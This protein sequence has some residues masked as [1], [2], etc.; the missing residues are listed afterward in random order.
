MEPDFWHGKWQRDETAFHE[1]KPNER[2]TCYASRL[3]L[4]PGARVFVPLCGKTADLIWLVDQGFRVSGNELSPIAVTQFFEGLE[5]TPEVSQVGQLVR[6]AVPG[7][8]IYQ[9]DVFDLSAEILGEVDA[10]YDRAA[11]VALPET[12]REKYAAHLVEITRAAPQLIVSFDYD[13]ASMTGPPFSVD[14]A[15]V[16]ALYDKSHVIALLERSPIVDLRTARDAHESV[17]LLERRI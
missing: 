17:Y 16:H 14:A 13:P 4:N 2:L 6:H 5:M 9:G 8:V 7:L 1:G 12:M 15:Q 3:K 10:V 11:L